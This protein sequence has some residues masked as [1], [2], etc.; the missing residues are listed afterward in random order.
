MDARK[1]IAV[2]ITAIAGGAWLLD[3]ASKKLVV[4]HLSR[5]PE[6]HGLIVLPNLVCFVLGTNHGGSMGIP[7][8]FMQICLTVPAIFMLSAAMWIGRRLHKERPIGTLMQI[9]LGLFLGGSLANWSERVLY[10]GV[11]DFIYTPFYWCI[12][13]VADL[14]ITFGCLIILFEGARLILT[15]NRACVVP[16]GSKSC[17]G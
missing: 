10:H 14:W 12:F 13:N 6:P 4:D 17:A 15:R 11:T 5:L 8:Q 16:D 7:P 3:A 2:T 1:Q 9:G